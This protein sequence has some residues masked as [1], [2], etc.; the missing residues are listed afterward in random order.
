MGATRHIYQDGKRI[1][2]FPKEVIVFMASFLHHVEELKSQTKPQLVLTNSQLKNGFNYLE[3]S[4]D[5]T[6]YLLVSGWNDSL[7][8]SLV[9]LLRIK[10]GKLMHQ[11]LVDIS[12]LNENFNKLQ[13]YGK[14]N[15]LSNLTT[16]LQHPFLGAD[17]SLIFGAGGRYK[18]DRNGKILWSFTDRCHH[19]IEKGN[20]DN[21]WMCS[22]NSN[23]KHSETLQIRDDAL[24]QIDGRTGEVLFEKSIY[25]IFIENGWNRGELFIN[26]QISTL[27][28]YLDYFHLNDVQPVLED[29]P[30]WK[31]GDVFFSLRHQNMLV[32]YRPATNQIIWF[33][34]GPWLRQ[35]DIDILDDHRISVFGNNV[36]D[37]KFPNRK[38][39]LI[40]GHNNQYVYDFKLDSVSTPF[41][42]LFKKEKV[43]TYTE[44]LSRIIADSLIFIEETNHGRIL[45]GN[46][47]N[48]IWSYV[49]RV[50][51]N[52]LSMFSWSRYITEEEFK[53]LKFMALK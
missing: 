31:K 48:A 3:K 27:T 45:F 20:G 2:G 43:G 33:K 15:D 47:K 37:A 8:Q 7:N 18:V 22:Y 13:T 30:F 53:S 11:W 39:L 41:T 16:S 40:D 51:E 1:S 42:A 25:E 14:Q 17:G 12:K 34:K 4:I 10:D 44:G 49:D 19:A 32:L 9:K 28:N 50:D 46:S 21:F 24:L 38:D 23:L 26:P 6:G 5:P 36:L 29:G 52:H 35:H